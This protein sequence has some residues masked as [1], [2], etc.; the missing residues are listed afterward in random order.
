MRFIVSGSSM[1]PDYMPGDK[2]WVSRF[3]YMLSKPKIG[4]VVVLS[5]PRDQRLILKRIVEIMRDGYFMKGDNERASTDSR[6]FGPVKKEDM[7]GKVLFRYKKG[8]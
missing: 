7:I 6:V 2:L 5:D 4:D 8:S 3:I 1:K